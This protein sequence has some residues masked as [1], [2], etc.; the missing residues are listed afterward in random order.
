V[1]LDNRR[2][3][4]KEGVSPVKNVRTTILCSEFDQI[5]TRSESTIPVLRLPLESQSIDCAGMS[6]PDDGSEMTKLLAVLLALGISTGIS[7]ASAIDSTHHHPKLAVVIVIDQMRG[8]YVTRF[9]PYFTGGLKRILTEGAVFDSAAHEHANTE[10]AVGHATLGTGCFPQHHGIVGNDFYDRAHDAIV[11]SV[12]DTTTRLIRT[13]A[14]ENKREDSLG[15]SA[16][17]LMRSGLGNWLKS[18]SHNR[19]FSLSLKDRSAILMAGQVGPNLAPFD[20][21]YWWDRKTGD[22]VTSTAYA[23][24]LPDWVNEFNRGPCKEMWKD[25]IWNRLLDSSQYGLYDAIGVDDNPLENDGVHTTFPHYFTVEKKGRGHF[26]A[27]Y[28]TPFA[29]QL[30]IRFVREL[31]AQE[32]VGQA[33]GQDILMFSCSAA[34]AVGHAYGPN[35]HEIFDYYLRLDRYLDTLLQTIDSTVGRDNYI[36]VLSSDHGCVELPPAANRVSPAEYKL[37]VTS[38]LPDSIPPARRDSLF[39]LL[40]TDVNFRRSACYL[41]VNTAVMDLFSRSIRYLPFVECVYTVE[42]PDDPGCFIS[43]NYYPPRIPDIVVVF[44]ESEY[45]TNSATGTSHGT[46][47]WYDRHVPLVFWGHGINSQHFYNRVRTVDMAPTIADLLGISPFDSIDGR[48][49]VARIRR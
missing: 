47:W 9:T 45:L 44:K 18:S 19:V 37:A 2:V 20:G 23:K 35:S 6:T 34:D 14:A 42:S 10:T 36:V 25:S 29:D 17:Y 39:Q 4:P 12:E 48:S 15:S 5:L 40:G 22:F 38:A 49:L 8:D 31:I 7:H 41:G 13:T 3:A 1:A 11:Y 32:K 26:D 28:P 16:H 24:T 30:L 21:I 33:E 27:V 46:P 43:N